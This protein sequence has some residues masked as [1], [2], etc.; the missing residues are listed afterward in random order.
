MNAALD[1][2]GVGCTSTIKR[3]A[4]PDRLERAKLALEALAHLVSG[5]EFGA[6]KT[7]FLPHWEVES[8]VVTVSHP[9][10]FNPQPG[11]R[12]TYIVETV[13]L[14][15]SFSKSISD[16]LGYGYAKVYYYAS[17]DS[18][19]VRP[20]EGAEEVATPMDA[21][22]KALDHFNDSRCG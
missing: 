5:L 8:I 9:L 17:K 3:E 20:Q 7:R 4:L 10:P 11:H 13:R 2:D 21:V 6:K 19:V 15:E 16:A 1:L 12:D 22:R 18:P 14:A